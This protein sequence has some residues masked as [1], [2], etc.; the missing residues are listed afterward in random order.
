[1]AHH[2]DYDV[3]Y[4]KWHSNLDRSGNSYFIASDAAY[5]CP[6]NSLWHVSHF[7]GIDGNCHECRRCSSNGRSKT[8]Y[9]GHT[10]HVAYRVPYTTSI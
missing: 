1:M 4:R 3:G 7:D 10:H 9:L 2:I 5:T 8:D 6:K